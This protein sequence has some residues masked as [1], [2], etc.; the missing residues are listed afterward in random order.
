MQSD[1]HHL[2]QKLVS[3]NGINNRSVT[4][5]NTKLLHNNCMQHI[6]I[7]SKDCSDT[8]IIGCVVLSENV[9]FHQF[10]DPR[11]KIGYVKQ[12]VADR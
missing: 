7:L 12:K 1:S 9:K 11:D 6:Y 5:T 10:K 8:P 2:M 4:N 3:E